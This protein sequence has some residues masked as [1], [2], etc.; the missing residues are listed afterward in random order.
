MKEI[1]E[2]RLTEL[3]DAAFLAAAHK[4]VERAIETDTPVIL[5]ENGKVTRGRSAMRETRISKAKSTFAYSTAPVI[6]AAEL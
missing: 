4:V 5:S 6:G 2:R 3:A 1:S